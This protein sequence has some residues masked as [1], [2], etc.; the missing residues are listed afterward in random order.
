M[1]YLIYADG[2]C[3]GNGKADAR[4]EGSF[5][6]YKIGAGEPD[7]AALA[8]ER[9][10][11]FF[12]RLSF[13]PAPGQRSTNNVAEACT[14]R[15]TMLW[16]LKE[17]LFTEDNHLTICMDSQLVIYQFSGLYKTKS[18]QIREIYQ[19]I[20]RAFKEHK[21]Q[22]GIDP[23]KLFT[24]EWISGETMKASVIGH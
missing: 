21:E 2:A 4:M 16:A 9:P 19:S 17:G 12:P 11:W 15:Q 24:L 8:L 14:L 22:T 10:K 6:V 23:E 18:Q 3:P 13:L 5:A 7:H 1:R 20:Y